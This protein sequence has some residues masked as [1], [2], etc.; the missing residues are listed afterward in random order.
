MALRCRE[1]APSTTSDSAAVL[2]C[3]GRQLILRWLPSRRMPVTAALGQ[4]ETYAVRQTLGGTSRH[5]WLVPAHLIRDR[6]ERL[7]QQPSV[8]SAAPRVP[9]PASPRPTSK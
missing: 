2:N 5:I 3:R 4:L 7:S 9:A 8:S 1:R 6:C